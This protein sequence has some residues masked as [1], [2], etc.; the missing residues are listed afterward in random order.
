MER[1]GRRLKA[2]TP[3]T[4]DAKPPFLAVRSPGQGEPAGRGVHAGGQHGGRGAR[5]PRVP[6]ARAPAPPPAAAPAQDGGAGRDCQPPGTLKRRS[7]LRAHRAT[8]A[9]AFV[10]RQLCARTSC[11]QLCAH[12]NNSGGQR[13]M[14]GGVSVSVLRCTAC[15]RSAADALPC[16]T[17]CA[18][19]Q[20][21]KRV[22]PPH[23]AGKEHSCD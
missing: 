9:A 20:Q 15:C 8:P 12:C 19:L 17:D 1:R 3:E 2:T 16:R 6:R 13:R 21:I 23:A 18:A 11:A 10:S 14:L 4:L 22:L 7:L 5:L